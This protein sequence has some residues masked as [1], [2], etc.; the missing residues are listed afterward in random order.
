MKYRELK[1]YKYQLVSDAY[2][3]IPEWFHI[4]YSSNFI[5]LSNGHLTIKKGYAW[6]GASGPA[7]DTKNF[8]FGSLIHDAMYQIIREREIGKSYRKEADKVL[9]KICIASGMS[10]FRAW[11]VYQ[12]VRIFGRFTLKKRTESEIKE[13]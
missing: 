12:A 5:Y 3:N 6:D 2:Y 8:M 11:Y 9:R 10:K 4:H 13:I 1:K 7:I